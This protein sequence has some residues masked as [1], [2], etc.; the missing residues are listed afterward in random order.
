[1]H[2]STLLIPLLAGAATAQNPSC[3]PTS[4]DTQVLQFASGLSSFIGGFFNSTVNSA[5]PNSSNATMQAQKRIIMGVE[6][7]N[8]LGSQAIDKVGAMAP[9]F[10]APSCSFTYPMPN[11]TQA[12]AFWAA[13][14]ETTVTGAF[15]ALAGFTQSPEVSFLMARLAA[16]H[17]SHATLIGSRVNSTLFAQNATSLVAAFPP[18]QVLSTRNETGSLGMF[19]GGCLTAPQSPCGPLAIGPLAATPSSGAASSTPMSST[20]MSSTPVASSTAAAIRKH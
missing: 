20:P 4:S 6:R 16:S 17:S 1:M 2:F 15:V 11:S 9:G 12:W 3:S 14:L 8:T 13:R 10:T 5:F 18:D 19:F 7:D